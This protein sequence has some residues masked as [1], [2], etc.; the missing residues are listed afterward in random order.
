MNGGK[1]TDGGKMRTRYIVLLIILSVFLGL[2]I[3][4]GSVV[5]AIDPTIPTLDT[6]Y[7]YVND[8]VRYWIYAGSE[9]YEYWSELIQAWVSAD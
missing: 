1:L 5:L 4:T 2:P 6:V 3:L 7:Y 9:I 8:T